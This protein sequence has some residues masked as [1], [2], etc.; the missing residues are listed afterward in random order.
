[1]GGLPLALSYAVLLVLHLGQAGNAGEQA[2]QSSQAHG[3]IAS[4]VPEQ[5]VLAKLAG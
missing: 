2:E 4:V 5:Q 1:M 3:G